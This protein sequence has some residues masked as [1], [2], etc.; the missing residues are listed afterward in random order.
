MSTEPT[1]LEQLKQ[2]DTVEFPG[3]GIERVGEYGDNVW[4]YQSI[5][6]LIGLAGV[7]QKRVFGLSKFYPIGQRVSVVELGYD[8]QKG[9]RL[10]KTVG[11]GEVVGYR[12]YD[13][14]AVVVGQLGWA[15][16]NVGTPPKIDDNPNV[17]PRPVFQRKPGST[18]PVIPIVELENGERKPYH[19]FELRRLKTRRQ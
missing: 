5:E 9:K 14:I 8:S 16:L 15:G 3:N 17:G 1:L 2:M 19:R 7:N 4:D 11:R 18:L 12:V 6:D 13:P 10:S